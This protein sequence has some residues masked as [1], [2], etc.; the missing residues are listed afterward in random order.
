MDTL[1]CRNESD[2]H[3]GEQQ[4]FYLSRNYKA[5]NAGPG[6]E[7]DARKGEKR[8]KLRGHNDAARDDQGKATKGK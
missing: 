3:Q 8:R 6:Q 1:Q 7:P 5:F 2:R 4:R